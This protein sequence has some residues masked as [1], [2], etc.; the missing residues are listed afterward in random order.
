MVDRLTSLLSARKNSYI[1]IGVGL[2][3]ALVF[4]FWSPSTR[5]SEYFWSPARGDAGGIFQLSR[6]WPQELELL[7]DCQ[8]IRAGGNGLVFST[9]DISIE[10]IDNA[11]YLRSVRDKEIDLRVA[12]P[13][14]NCQVRHFFSAST[15][16]FSISAGSNF[17]S[18]H[19]KGPTYPR[20]HELKTGAYLQ[21]PIESVRVLTRPWGVDHSPFRALLGLVAATF[22]LLALAGLWLR[23]RNRESTFHWRKI[24][25][26]PQG[27]AIAAFL[28]FAAF[29][30]PPF[31]DD[32]WVIARVRNFTTTGVFSN[33][34]DASDSWFPQGNA[35][36]LAFGFL[37]HLD[38]PLIWI[39]IFVL[40]ML[41]ATWEILRKF[42]LEEYLKAK[43]NLLWVPASFFAAFASVW[44]L[45]L[46][47]ESWVLLYLAVAWAAMARFHR[48]GTEFSLFFALTS[49]GFA[50]SAHQSGWAAVP[51]GAVVIYL[52]AKRIWQKEISYEFVIIPT[53][54]ALTLTLLYQ[55]ILY[56]PNL[57][58]DGVRS[59]SIQSA[60]AGSFS[61]ELVRYRI[62]LNGD[63]G[64]RYVT[65]ALL[66]LFVLAAAYLIS[67]FDSFKSRLWG[68]CILCFVALAFTQSKWSWHLGVDVIPGVV[69]ITLAFLF[70][71]ESHEKRKPFFLLLLP[72]ALFLVA[73]CLSSTNQLSNF[74]LEN[75]TWKQFSETFGSTRHQAIWFVLIV[76]SIVLAAFADFGKKK[77]LRK[78]AS[79][80]LAAVVLLLPFLSLVWVGIDALRS[81]A[82]SYPRQNVQQF[83][84]E[85]V[86]DEP[87]FV[88][89]LA[90]LPTSAQPLPEIAPMIPD[91]HPPYVDAGPP[92]QFGTKTWGT[93]P[94]F[95]EGNRNSVNGSTKSDLLIGEFASPQ[96]AVTG[97]QYVGVVIAAGDPKRIDFSLQFFDKES[98]MIS[99]RSLSP[100]KAE[101]WETNYAKVPNGA[102]AARIVIDDKKSSLGG[103]GAVSE[104]RGA[105]TFNS[106][107]VKATGSIFIGPV[108]SQKYPC[109]E[110][111]RP[112]GGLWPIVNYV[113]QEDAYLAEAVLD[114]RVV[115]NGSLCGRGDLTCLRTPLYGNAVVVR[116]D[117]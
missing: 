9:G 45:S 73:T 13:E 108:E 66:I 14:G 39:R 27:I 12:L 98:K 78:I 104:I 2:F 101:R 21:N 59:F 71:D 86:C 94:N 69:I 5:S 57:V 93:W 70:Q 44:L 84:G 11:L 20:V 29:L 10:A 92:T 30:V 17:D 46:R 63:A 103:W 107:E 38:V 62:W 35:H 110:S 41:V 15:G 81:D 58:L 64:A 8:K 77:D 42:V 115:I 23:Q 114:S 26:S 96:Y 91:G 61:T 85:N 90:A 50:F 3:L 54:C 65:I 80:S 112:L 116:K 100:Q 75:S 31:Y 18:A 109:L 51:I 25:P 74:D 102:T 49:V 60:H 53:L 32:G 48:R 56:G 105:I 82:W 6:T 68:L 88:T 4:T 22:V 28:F 83:F 97:R 52:A 76:G 19:L 1:I 95:L 106:N 79:R 87:R 111:V 99:S 37:V 47:A 34:Y 72:A 33:L 36:E 113:T 89:G 117:R 7:A 55:F 24:R 67:R 16:E 40:V 43:P